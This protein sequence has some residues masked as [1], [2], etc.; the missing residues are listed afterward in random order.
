MLMET[1]QGLCAR[2]TSEGT[3][4]LWEKCCNGPA[5]K[6]VLAQAWEGHVRPRAQDEI[7]GTGCPWRA[8]QLS[9]LGSGQGPE[10]YGGNWPWGWGMGCRQTLGVL[11]WPL[12]LSS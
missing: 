4:G 10:G 7:G 8:E 6:R 3:W 1:S 11:Y 12:A 5:A 9:L 2:G